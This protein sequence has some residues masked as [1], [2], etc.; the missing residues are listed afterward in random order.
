MGSLVSVGPYFAK[1]LLCLSGM[2]WPGTTLIP[3][4]NGGNTGG[5]AQISASQLGELKYNVRPLIRA[6]IFLFAFMDEFEIIIREN[7]LGFLIILG[8]LWSL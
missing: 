4:R 8:V 2:S 6:K 7:I 1:K 5:A 3:V